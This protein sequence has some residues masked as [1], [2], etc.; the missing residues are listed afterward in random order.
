MRS[1]RGLSLCAISPCFDWG[2]WMMGGFGR[3]WI[4][5]TETAGMKTKKS[6]GGMKWLKLGLDHVEGEPFFKILRK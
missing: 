1:G 2:R 6:A 3:V 4:L 5:M